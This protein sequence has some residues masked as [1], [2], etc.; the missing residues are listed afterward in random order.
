M[1][2]KTKSACELVISAAGPNIYTLIL[3]L[4]REGRKTYKRLVKI[5][6]RERGELK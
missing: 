1:A 4:Y 2:K 3:G 5:I 6:V